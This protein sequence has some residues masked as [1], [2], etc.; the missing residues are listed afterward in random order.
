[1][2]SRGGRSGP[3]PLLILS[4]GK[5]DNKP[6]TSCCHWGPDKTAIDIEG[7][8]V[9]TPPDNISIPHYKLSEFAEDN[10]AIIIKICIRTF[11]RNIVFT[12][13]YYK[14][15]FLIQDTYPEF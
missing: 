5:D 12:C 8:G 2:G 14:I 4:A 13:I 15:S 6:V 3:C 11:L 7:V 10:V 1:V 9:P